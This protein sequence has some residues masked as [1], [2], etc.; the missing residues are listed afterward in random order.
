[1]FIIFGGR[2]MKTFTLICRHLLHIKVTT[3]CT[4][5]C[6]GNFPSAFNIKEKRERKKSSFFV[7]LEMFKVVNQASR[8]E[9]SPI[10][11]KP[12]FFL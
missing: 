11:N 1:M 3:I 10:Y 12:C 6:A 9:I 7:L 4:V 2:E 5:I 8:V